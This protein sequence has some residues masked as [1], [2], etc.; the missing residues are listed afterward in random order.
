MKGGRFRTTRA[1]IWYA[2]LKLRMEN[3]SSN[4]EIRENGK[5]ISGWIALWD[6]INSLN[7]KIKHGM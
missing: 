4:A 6:I 2:Q 3:Q 5:W 7:N 1:V